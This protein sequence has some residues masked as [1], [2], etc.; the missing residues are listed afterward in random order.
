MRTFRAISLFFMALSAPCAAVA[1]DYQ[2]PFGE[3]GAPSQGRANPAYDQSRA[4]IFDLSPDVVDSTVAAC[5]GAISEWAQQFNPIGVS[6][7]LLR[8]VQRGWMGQRN[9]LLKVKVDYRRKYGVETRQARIDCTVSRSGQVTVA[10][11][12]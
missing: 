12:K 7:G 9:A 4:G 5:N 11:S 1:G 3:K 6:T 10:E 8:P 2:H